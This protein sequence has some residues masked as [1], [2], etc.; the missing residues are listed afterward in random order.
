MEL[1]LNDSKPKNYWFNFP[2]NNITKFLSIGVKHSVFWCVIASHAIWGISLLFNADIQNVTAINSL[3]TLMGIESRFIESF[4]YL[5]ACALCFVELYY[6]NKP[7]WLAYLADNLL[8]VGLQQG[9]LVLSAYGSYL[10]IVNGVYADGTISSRIHV[11]ADQN[12]YISV[13]IIHLFAIIAL[14][15]K[16]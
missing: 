13:C 2:M 15:T 12:I 11:L 4:I 10:S 14:K 7:K 16:K 3:K 6:T 1:E 5:L 9:L 8:L